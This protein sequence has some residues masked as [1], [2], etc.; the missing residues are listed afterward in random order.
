MSATRRSAGLAMLATGAQSYTVGT[1]RA[2][3]FIVEFDRPVD[4]T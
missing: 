2:D 3:A 1:R 4:I